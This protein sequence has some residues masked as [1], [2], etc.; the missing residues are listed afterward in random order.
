M[1]GIIQQV[2]C[3]GSIKEE[4]KDTGHVFSFVEAHK[5]DGF[6]TGQMCPYIVLEAR[7]LKSGYKHGGSYCRLPRKISS[8]PVFQLL[9]NTDGEQQFGGIASRVGSTK[10]QKQRQKHAQGSKLLQSL[11]RIG[12]CLFYV[13][14]VSVTKK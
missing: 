14:K 5:L 1:D 8:L 7:S 13:R 10:H 9:L 3:N 2:V 6:Q 11:E 4:L 12:C